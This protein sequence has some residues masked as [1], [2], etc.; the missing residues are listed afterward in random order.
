MV[1]NGITTGTSPSTF[2]PDD[3]LTRGQMAALLWRLAERPVPT[4]AHPFADVVKAWQGDPVS[5]L[6]GSGITTGTSPT[7]FSPADSLTR[8]QIATFLHRYKGTPTV[9]IDY[10]HPTTPVCPAPVAG[11]SGAP[12]LSALDPFLTRPFEGSFT[13]LF[14]GEGTAYVPDDGTLWL[15]DD[16]STTTVLHEIDATTGALL[17]SISIDELAAAPPLGGGMPLAGT[18]RADDLE[19]LAYDE[20]TDQLYAFSGTSDS[21]PTTPTVFR[22]TR[23]GDS[24]GVESYQPLDDGADSAAVGPDGMIYVVQDGVAT[25]DDLRTYDYLTNTFGPRF[26][27]PGVRGAIWGIGFSPDGSDLWIGNEVTTLYR[28]DWATKTI[29]PGYRLPLADWMAE[30]TGIEIIS[31]TLHILDGDDALDSSDPLKYAVHRLPISTS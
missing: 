16:N 2:S 5:W 13:K 8:G 15:V 6:F 27:I 9:G 18:H 1:E 29:D 7:H 31:G 25:N 4:Q 14:D 11:P 30:P 3:L 22:L 21:A 12:T 24:F 10:V 17:D 26:S 20:N 28:V 23:D 19:A